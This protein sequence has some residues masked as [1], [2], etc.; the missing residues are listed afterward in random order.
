METRRICYE[1]NLFYKRREVMKTLPIVLVGLLMIT[2]C[3]K[4]ETNAP[5]HAPPIT[6][7]VSITVTPHIIHRGDSVIVSWTSPDAMQ[8]FLDSSPVVDFTPCV[9]QF[10]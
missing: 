10:F 7:T 2:G 4:E 1:M 6:P 9:R 8:C 3:S 5:P